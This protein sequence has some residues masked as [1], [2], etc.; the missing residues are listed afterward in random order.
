MRSLFIL[1]AV[2]LC[3]T[4]LFAAPIRNQ[5][6][7]ITQPDG[8]TYDV[9]ASGDEF[10]NY[11]HDE[12]GYTIIPDRTTGW[13]CYAQ[14][15]GEELAPS[16]WRV[17]EV[18]PA[19][20][21]L[22]PRLLPSERYYRQRREARYAGVRDETRIPVTGSVNNVVIYIRFADQS[23]FELTR[24]YYDQK[25]NDHTTGAVSMYNYYQEVSYGNLE[26][27]SHHFPP[28]EMSTN[29]SYQDS[30]PR[31]YFSP[32]SAANTIGYNGDYEYREREHQLLSDAVSALESTVPDT[33]NIDA[34][35]DNYVDNVCFIIRGGNDG[36]ADLLWAHRW[37]L[38]TYNVTIHGK[39]VYDYTFQ[40][41]SQNTVGPLCHEMFHSLGAPD[42]YH[43]YDSAYTPVGEWDLMDGGEAH[44]GAYMKYRYATWIP[45][46]P[47]ISQPGVY[48][49]HSLLSPQNNCYRINSPNTSREFF[50]VEYRRQEAGTF[51]AQL[52]GSGL[53]VYRINDNLSG[54]GNADGP[55]DEV[56][57]YRP[58]GTN[59]TNGS[60]SDANFSS[61]Y[62][63]TEF[64]D[65]TNP[66]CFLTNDGEGG[67][68]IHQV[69][70]CGDSI[71]FILD[72]QLGFAEGTVS[73]DMPGSPLNE[74]VISFEDQ[75][76]SPNSSGVFSLAY[77]QGT[78][79]MS[80]TLS[81]FST[82]VQQVTINAGESTDVAFNLVHLN[83]PENLTC[84]LGEQ[85]G[86]TVPATFTWQ[87]APNEGFE[88]Y[89]VWINVFGYYNTIA[90]P[91]ETMYQVNLTTNRT[92]RFYVS[93]EYA[94][95]ESDSSNVVTIDF[96][97]VAGTEQT[98]TVTRLC[99]NTPN[100]FNPETAIRYELAAPGNAEIRIYD[101]RGRLVN[102]LAGE[103]PSAGA[104]Q[105]VW[106]GRDATGRICASGV[107][108]YRLEGNGK[109]MET[110][111][112]VLLK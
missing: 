73:T 8:S 43:Y 42:L 66:S 54:Q 35:N 55:P 13:Y 58:G 53:L 16:Q 90:M 3:A 24:E 19:S 111:K 36:W 109:Q 112:M 87:C 81:G 67:I 78:Y 102:T 75:T 6:M 9:L 44:M 93:A 61:D 4:M 99:G 91:T 17:G 25:F 22:A 60:T 26:L 108:F 89:K 79:S 82:D 88:R 39:R 41:E 37:V 49:L 69:G 83:A 32:Y 30:H 95:G 21:G 70:A 94:N 62:G 65:D 104:H 10:F 98:P 106:S 11:L 107:Y 59:Y 92:Y 71:S 18:D 23:E 110:K 33:L 84:E 57:C 103:D 80:A 20:T 45:E 28:C 77:L 85:T 1:S 46:I 31:D 29:L 72:P 96:T 64:N 76:L 68:F 52:P 27:I 47:V 86:N 51:E 100:P 97:A 56:Y 34:D 40:P 50:V 15:N 7:T 12:A 14:R 63:L 2:L 105:I 101:I 48:T 74:A 5:P 38:W